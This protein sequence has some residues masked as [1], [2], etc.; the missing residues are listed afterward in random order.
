MALKLC[1][2]GLVYVRQHLLAESIALKAKI[3]SIEAEVRNL[4]YGRDRLGDFWW[5]LAAGV[6][7][8]PPL[9]ALDVVSVR[10]K[11]AVIDV[12]TEFT[13]VVVRACRMP[14]ETWLNTLIDTLRRPTTWRSFFDLINSLESRIER[15]RRANLVR[16]DAA[17]DRLRD[18]R[19]RDT[20]AQVCA[21]TVRMTVNAIDVML[22]RI[23][24]GN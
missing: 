6:S 12:I 16:Q 3:I 23:A 7:D 21:E 18:V 22:Q 9:L 11:N 14:W 15:E 19:A 1:R 17:N 20:E 13:P 24:A 8:I 5:A 4:D 10:D 2:D